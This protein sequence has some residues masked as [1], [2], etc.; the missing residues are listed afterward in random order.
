MLAPRWIPW[1]SFTKPNNWGMAKTPTFPA[2]IDQT[3]CID[4]SIFKGWGLLKPDLKSSGTYNDTRGGIHKGA[5]DFFLHTGISPYCTFSGCFRGVP[6]EKTIEMQ[7]KESNLGEKIRSRDGGT[8]FYFICPITGKRC[9]KLYVIGGQL[10]SSKAFGLYY[11][12]QALSKN[13]LSWEALFGAIEQLEKLTAEI[14]SGKVMRSYN[15]KITR[16]YAR[17]MK[18]RDRLDSMICRM[19]KARQFDLNEELKTVQTAAGFTTIEKRSLKWFIQFYQL[20]CMA[21]EWDLTGQIQVFCISMNNVFTNNRLIE[22]KIR[23]YTL[24]KMAINCKILGCAKL[25]K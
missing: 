11:R 16:R 14:H 10:G 12:Q 4:I 13:Q 22:S 1:G 9:R 18:E 2:M 8:V 7:G 21:I 3:F 5:I 19:F 17:L 6:F 24:M 25:C 23:H 20:S 15:G